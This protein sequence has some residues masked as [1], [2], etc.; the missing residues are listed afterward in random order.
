MLDGVYRTNAKGEPEFVETPAPSD[1]EVWEVLERII[2]RVMKQLVRR[3]ILVE[4]QGELYLADADDDY[5]EARTLRPLHRGSCVYRIAFGPRAG[6]KVLT[7]QGALPREISGKQKLCANLQGFSLHAGVRCGAGQR[8]TL[9]R[10]CR[11]ITRPAL[12]NDRVQVNAS[13]QV[14]LKLKTPWRD[15]TTHQVMSPLEFMQRLAALVPRPRL[16]LIRFG[17]RITSLREMS[18]PLL[19]GRGAG[20]KRQAACQGGASTM[21]GACSRSAIAGGRRGS[22][23]PADAL[24]VG[25][26]TEAG[27]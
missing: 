9:E 19:R 26:A 24:G 18:I 6:Q 12:A 2:K 10:L 25:E 5:E 8:K 27:V 14:E 4:D 20:P 23:R 21:R 11:Y 13:G 16:H 3:G 15:G 1:E 22:S 7:L 17:G